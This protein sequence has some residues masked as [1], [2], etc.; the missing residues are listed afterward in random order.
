MHPRHAVAH[1]PCFQA[2]ERVRVHVISPIPV[3]DLEGQVGTQL[4]DPSPIEAIGRVFEAQQPSQRIV[5]CA[6]THVTPTNIALEVSHHQHQ[7]I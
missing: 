7:A 5:V 2:A 3:T 6:N 1:L 4:G